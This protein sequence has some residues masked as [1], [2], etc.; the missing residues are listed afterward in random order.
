MAHMGKVVLLTGA[1][2]TG[3]STLRRALSERIP[4]L[5]A[6]DYGQLLMERKADQGIKLRYDQL[7]RRSSAVIEPTDVASL[8]ERVVAGVRGLRRTMHV[9]IDSHAVTREV[10]GFR[11]IP[12]SLDRLRRLRLDAVL[13]LRCDPRCLV[14][15]I[16]ERAEGRQDVTVELA[17]EHQALQAGLGLTYAVACGCPAYIL[18]TTSTDESGVVDAACEI[19]AAVGI[20]LRPTKRP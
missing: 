10:Y 5:R 19:L 20:G 14:E 16:R 7:R 1:P 12:F 3:K 6:F 15:R 2:A 13:V 9:L 8:D 11:A 18:D 17:R 4:N